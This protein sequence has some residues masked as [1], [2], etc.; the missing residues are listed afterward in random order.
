MKALALLLLL[1]AADDTLV[2]AARD[3]KARRKKST[4]KVL[5]NADVKKSK[6]KIATTPNVSGEPVTPEP[7]LMEKH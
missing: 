1:L 2:D 5:T 3:A 6:G 4:T 7:T